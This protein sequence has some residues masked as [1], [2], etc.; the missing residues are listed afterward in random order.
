MIDWSRAYQDALPYVDFLDR[1]ANP[2][3]RRSLGM[4]CTREITLASAPSGHCSAALCDYNT[5][6]FSTVPGAVIVS[7]KCQSSII[8]PRPARIFTSG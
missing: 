2:N 4:Q 8:L 7:I 1:H 3:Q 5:S 6:S